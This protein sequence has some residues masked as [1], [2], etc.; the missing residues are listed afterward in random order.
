MKEVPS[1]SKWVGMVL[2]CNECQRSYEIEV[3]DILHCRYSHKGRATRFFILPCNHAK[4]IPYN[5]E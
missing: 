3:G 1:R 2:T 4:I 5:D